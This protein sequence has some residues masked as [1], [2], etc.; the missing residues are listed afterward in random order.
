[1]VYS[2]LPFF[3]LA[4]FSLLLILT[5]LPG[6]NSIISNNAQKRQKRRRLTVTIVCISVYF[7]LFTSCG[8]VITV[9]FVSLNSSLQG[10]VII[11]LLDNISF[12]Y[13]GLTFFVLYF[14]NKAYAAEFK[15]ILFG[16][17]RII[18]H[19]STNKYLNNTKKKA[20]GTSTQIQ[21]INKR[22]SYT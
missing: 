4:V 16:L 18:K 8:S 10:K 13:N 5:V 1:M 6:K 20:S 21:V 11:T 7:I 17:F 22:S 3:L 19:D 12:C 14:S 15:R 9:M 2:F